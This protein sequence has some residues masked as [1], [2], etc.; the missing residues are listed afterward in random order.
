MEIAGRVNT[1]MDATGDHQWIHVDVERATPA[2][3]PFD[4]PIA[5]GYPTLSLGPVPLPQIMTV[6]GIKDWASALPAAGPVPSPVS[7]WVPTSDWAPPSTPSDLP[8]GGRRSM[9]FTFEVEGAPKPAAVSEI[10]FRYSE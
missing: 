3:S 7:R 1:F 6:K 5:H 8:A 9:T 4:G 10:I 2:E